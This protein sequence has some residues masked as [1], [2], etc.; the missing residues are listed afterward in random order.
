MITRRES[1]ERQGQSRRQFAAA[2]LA[3]GAASACAD[4]FTSSRLSMEAK[5]FV[6]REDFDKTSAIVRARFP[7]AVLLDA[8]AAPHVP[9]LIVIH[10]A[11]LPSD[12]VYEV[13]R[14]GNG[15]IPSSST[16]CLELFL[17]DRSV[18][19][20]RHRSLSDRAAQW[21]TDGLPPATAEIG[22]YRVI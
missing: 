12:A 16:D 20:L 19:V 6:S 13:R 21:G 10:G 8:I 15:P 14:Y 18:L 17:G 11:L 3:L 22:F 2:C 9:E 7:D 1:K 5:R 4:A